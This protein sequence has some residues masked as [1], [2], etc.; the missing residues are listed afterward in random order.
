MGQDHIKAISQGDSKNACGKHQVEMH[1][2]EP[3][4]FSMKIVKSHKYPLLRQMYEGRLVEDFRGDEILNQRGE[5]GC[6]LP[7]DIMVEGEAPNPKRKGREIPQAGEEC[8]EQKLENDTRPRRSKIPR[9]IIQDLGTNKTRDKNSSK[10]EKV[11]TPTEQNVNNQAIEIMASN[12]KLEL[13][14]VKLEPIL[15]TFEVAEEQGK[16]TV[17]RLDDHEEERLAIQGPSNVDAKVTRT[18]KVY[19]LQYVKNG[20]VQTYNPK[21]ADPPSTKGKPKTKKS[22]P[23]T[24]KKSCKYKVQPTGVQ[25]PAGVQSRAGVQSP[26]GDQNQAGGQNPTGGQ[27]PAG[28]QEPAGVRFSSFQGPAGGQSAEGGQSPAGT[29]AGSLRLDN[30]AGVNL[31]C[32][33]VSCCEECEQKPAN[34]QSVRAPPT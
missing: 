30:A 33:R 8:K 14:K 22:T 17:N 29:P 3:W 2:G 24:G 5:W 27:N 10:Q 31:F 7:P 1:Q 6:N 25:N 20:Q 9:T 32:T 11:N 23:S 18:S 21:K 4:D 34:R 12:V 26:I 15:T 16:T 28:F 13:V 19:E